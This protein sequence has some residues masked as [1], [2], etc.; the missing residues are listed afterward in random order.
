MTERFD[1]DIL[2]NYWIVE[3]IKEHRIW[4]KTKL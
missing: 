3:T 2:I 4:I 1:S